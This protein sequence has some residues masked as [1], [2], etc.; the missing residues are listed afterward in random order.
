DG[1]EKLMGQ[2]RYTADLPI[3]GLLHARLILSPYAHARIRHVDK[4][5]ALALPGVATVLMAAD[6]PMTRSRE[7][8]SARHRSPLAYEYVLF[9]G[10]PVAVVLAADPAVAEDAADLVAIDYE[11]LEAINDP[12]AAMLPGA[13][14]V[15]PH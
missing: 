9:R 10:Q 6:L 4:S 3:D 13:A 8:E 7:D 11:P 5:A 12:L 15:H 1:P 14:P 2:T